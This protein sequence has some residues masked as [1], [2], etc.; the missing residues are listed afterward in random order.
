MRNSGRTVDD[1]AVA[2]PTLHHPKMLLQNDQLASLLS[3]PS[4]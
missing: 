2:E 3:T 1:S 4:H